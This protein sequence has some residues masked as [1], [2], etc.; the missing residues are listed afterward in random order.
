MSSRLLITCYR[1]MARDSLNI[2]V[3]AP[4]V[5]PIAECFLD[6]G[7]ESVASD[8]FPQ[9]TTFICIRPEVDCALAFGQNPVANPD[10]HRIEAGEKCFY[11]VHPGHRLAVII[12]SPE[13]ETQS[14]GGE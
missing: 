10:Y 12:V 6:I 4:L 11:G 3:G 13:I 2:P 7:P 14:S 1:D 5:P 9:Y 8:P